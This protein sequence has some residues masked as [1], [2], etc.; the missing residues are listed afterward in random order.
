M[1]LIK[2]IDKIV[3]HIDLA[4]CPIDLRCRMCSLGHA[5][6]LTGY[7]TEPSRGGG[8]EGSDSVELLE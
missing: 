5:T 4:I 2:A 6:D 8:P 7:C 3:R 1:L